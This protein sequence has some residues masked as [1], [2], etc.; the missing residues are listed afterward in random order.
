MDAIEF[1]HND[2]EQVLGMLSRLE[3]DAKPVPAA[4]R[5]T[6][7]AAANWSPN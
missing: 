3:Q 1:L 7:V 4:T 6:F 5:T 2:H